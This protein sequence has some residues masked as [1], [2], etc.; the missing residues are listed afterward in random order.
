MAERGIAVD[1]ST[2]HR[3]AIKLLPVL[4]KAFRRCKRATGKSWQMD[5]TYV[6][7]RGEWRYLYRA[8]DKATRR[9]SSANQ[10][11]KGCCPAPASPDPCLLLCSRSTQCIALTRQAPDEPHTVAGPDVNE[12]RS[13]ATET[14]SSTIPPQASSAPVQPVASSPKPIATTTPPAHAPSAFAMLKAE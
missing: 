9:L 7:I 3:W 1:H 14:P 13:T 10:V 8:V 4:E 5:E 6:K 11:V 12:R 2:V